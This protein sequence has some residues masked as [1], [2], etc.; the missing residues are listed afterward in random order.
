MPRAFELRQKKA[1]VVKSARALATAAE[2]AKRE[3]TAEE[4]EQFNGFLSQ[5]EAHEVEARRLD[6]LEGLESEVGKGGDRVGDPLPHNDPRN[7]RNG[8]HGYSVLKALRQS[9]QRRE[10]KGQLDGVEMETHLELEKRSGKDAKGVLIPFDIPADC[11]ETR[12]LDTTAGIGSIPTVLAPTIIDILRTRMVVR[13]AG[14]TVM[15]DMQGLFA[16][17]RQSVAG[18]FNWVAEGSAPTATNQKID[19]VPFAPKTAAAYTDYTRRFLEQTNQ[20]AENFARTDLMKVIAR[21]VD[22]AALH[23]AG[24][25]NEPLGILTNTNIPLV[26]LGTNGDVPTYAA[27]VNLETNIAKANADVGEMRYLTNAQGRSKLKQTL[28]VASSTFPIYLWESNLPPGPEGMPRGV[29]NGY[30]TLV[31]NQLRSDLA[32]GSGTNLSPV[33]FGNFADLI[34]AFWSGIDVIVDPYTGSSTGSIRI[35]V[36]QDCDVNVRHPESFSAIVDMVTT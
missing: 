19:Q 21:G 20:D 17:P 32:K 7:T 36:F 18:S 27:L 15:S 13:S 12:A 28:K 1:E 30:E 3:L 6:R 11:R 23:G 14:A 31:S 33:V 5:A 10:G 35:A 26:A 9:L 8:R 24:T 29:V 25:S 4:L 22:K 16:I 2:E 34:I